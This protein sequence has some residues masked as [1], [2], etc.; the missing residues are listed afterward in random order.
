MGEENHNLSYYTTSKN[1]IMSRLSV[2]ENSKTNS[3]PKKRRNQ[4]VIELEKKTMMLSI[5]RLETKLLRPLK[6]LKPLVLVNV[7]T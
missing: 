3:N 7:K 5:L 2:N 4:F 6:K 1:I